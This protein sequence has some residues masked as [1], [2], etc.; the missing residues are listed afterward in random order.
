MMNIHLVDPRATPHSHPRPSP[1][2]SPSLS[3]STACTEEFAANV[4]WA[5][6][7]DPSPLSKDLRYILSWEAA[8]ER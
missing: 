5:L 2:L 8:T 4:Y 7:N 1:S 6:N 3:L